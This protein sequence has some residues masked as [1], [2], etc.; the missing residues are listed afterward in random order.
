MM[1]VF[2]LGDS[3]SAQDSCTF[4]LRVYDQIGDGWDGSFVYI[5]SGAGSE[6]GYAHTGITANAADSVRFF[7]IRVRRRFV[8]VF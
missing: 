6:R 5:R 8:T 1:L 4:R 3:V 2:W 7:D